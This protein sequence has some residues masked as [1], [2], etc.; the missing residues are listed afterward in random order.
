V[1][2][3]LRWLDLVRREL[4]A[5]DAR[6][7]L[8]GRDPSEARLIHMR[9]EGDMRVVVVFTEPPDDRADRLDRLRA[10]ADSFS[11]LLARARPMGGALGRSRA[12]ELDD[13]LE[14]LRLRVEAVSALVVDDTSPM[15]WGWSEAS[16]GDDDVE[17]LVRLAEVWGRAS[18]G[19]IDL[20]SLLAGAE[21]PPHLGQEPLGPIVRE[22]RR[23]RGDAP[24]RDGAAWRQRVL[25]GRALGVV[26]G[27]VGVN[28]RVAAS[29][30]GFGCLART[31]A[32]I[33]RL[34]L[35]FDGSFSELRA[36][37]EALRAL[38]RI[39]HLVLAL[40]PIDPGPKGARVL[41]LPDRPK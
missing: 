31:F 41:K 15:I 36:D 20:L 22:V 24:E 34:V 18:A 37:G 21:P 27:V 17:A 1:D 16:R 30:E 9:V 39:E 14:G 12:P 28:A 40:R 35:V 5:E 25:C 32:G 3:L 26:Q 13:T 8:G 23:L 7:E 29:E 6:I 19:R 38:P 11:G 10:L 2:P 4:G 33:Y